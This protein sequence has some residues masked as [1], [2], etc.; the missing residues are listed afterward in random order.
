MTTMTQNQTSPMTPEMEKG[1]RSLLLRGATRA[2]TAVTIMV[3]DILGHGWVH[4]RPDHQWGFVS[5]EGYTVTL[6]GGVYIVSQSGRT[7]IRIS[8][9][10]EFTLV[11]EGIT[12]SRGFL[13]VEEDIADADTIEWVCETYE[14]LTGTR[15][16]WA[17]LKA[18]KAHKARLALAR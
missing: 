4:P 6:D 8:P 7:H 17:S 2:A 1:I 5:P 12:L 14:A 10:G 13:F 15:P 9:E 16:L 11:R 18:E 3:A